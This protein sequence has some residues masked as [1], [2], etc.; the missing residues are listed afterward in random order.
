MS[1]EEKRNENESDPTAAALGIGAAGVGIFGLIKGMGPILSALKFIGVGLKWL[2]LV[3]KGGALAAKAALAALLIFGAAIADLGYLERAGI[4]AG[5]VLRA[6]GE[7]AWPIKR[8]DLLSS[9]MAVLAIMP[10]RAET[11]SAV[12]S[13]EGSVRDI[14]KMIKARY[15]LEAMAPKGAKTGIV[16]ADT[17]QGPNALRKL[18]ED[19]DKKIFSIIGHNEGGHFVFPNHES[20]QLSTLAEM[21]SKAQKQCIFVSCRSDYFLSSQV[22]VARDISPSEAVFLTRAISKRVSLKSYKPGDTQELASD[23]REVVLYN[24]DYLEVKVK[25]TVVTYT[26]GGVAI[27]GAVLIELKGS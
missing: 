19:P 15:E 20:I 13:R 26:S 2:F 18:L 3:I 7:I 5:H 11:F 8:A 27:S 25:V 23:I 16:F 1:D 6:V 24:S 9:D 10:N 12:F 17:D 21:C 4:Y 14:N 22:G